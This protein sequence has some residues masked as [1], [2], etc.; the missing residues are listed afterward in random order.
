M[1][2]TN[3][4]KT[5]LLALGL[6]VA[7]SC[8]KDDDLTQ[9]PIEDKTIVEIVTDNP[10]FSLLRTAV[11]HAELVSTLQ[12]TG[13]FT[14]FAP[15]DDAFKKAGLESATSITSLPKE[16]VKSIL[17]YHTLPSKLNSSAIPTANNTAVKTVQE[18]NFYVTKNSSGVF[19]NGSQVTTADLEAKNGVIHVV[20]NVLF[21]ASGNLVESLS[22]N[23]DFSYLVAAVVRASSGNTN[24]AEVLQGNVPFTVFAPTNQAFINAGF[25][26]VQDIQATD[27]NLLATIL[28]SH[29]IEGR[30]FSNAVQNDLTVE[31]LGQGQLLFNISGGKVTV[32]GNGN[33]AGST[34]TKVNELSSNGV[35]HVID[36]VLLP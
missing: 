11:V 17:L 14:V 9:Q 36:T 26:T 28:V 7:S 4:F 13:N 31:N 27:P 16:T 2:T 12:G 1:N 21:P 34:I 15:T 29:V 3:L 24:V 5:S 33:T 6:F 23:D 32:K 30:I 35:V 18:D 22:A 25:A 20:D 19:V 10:N 8:S